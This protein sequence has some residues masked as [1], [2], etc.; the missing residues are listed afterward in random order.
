MKKESDGKQAMLL[1]ALYDTWHTGTSPY[2]ADEGSEEEA[3]EDE[4]GQL[5]FS[6]TIMTQSAKG[7][8]LEWL[9]DRIPVILAPS[10][11][12][13][14][15]SG[16]LNIGGLPQVP[17]AIT[18]HPVSKRI[19]AVSYSGEDCTTPVSTSYEWSINISCCHLSRVRRNFSKLAAV[20]LQIK[21]QVP[22]RITAFFSKAAV[23]AGTKRVDV[24]RQG[25][26]AVEY[27]ADQDALVEPEE[28]GENDPDLQEALRRS[29]EDQGSSPAS[30]VAKSGEKR[31]QRTAS[32]RPTSARKKPR[33]QQ[34]K[35]AVLHNQPKI[36]SLFRKGG[37]W[38]LYVTTWLCFSPQALT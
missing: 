18:S 17:Q 34:N 37:E 36:D 7:T 29:M 9:H 30:P 13:S 1:A 32:A 21:L 6:F 19:N 2:N 5:M 22:R 28:T 11:G 10:A 27:D 24:S 3:A 31:S 15:L 20:L 26:K 4:C 23:A 25:A 33:K 35:Q 38:C 16:T 14:W 8:S 12:K